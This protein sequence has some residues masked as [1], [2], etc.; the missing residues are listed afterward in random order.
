MSALGLPL[1]KQLLNKG[2]SAK[3]LLLGYHKS[4]IAISPV[5]VLSAPNATLG[6]ALLTTLGW[7]H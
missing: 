5:A 4:E 1:G 7:G 6:N 3:K 2:T